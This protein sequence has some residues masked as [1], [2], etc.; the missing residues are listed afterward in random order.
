M[1]GNVAK[2]LVT[3]GAGYVGSHTLRALLAAGHRAVVLDDLRA[4]RAAFTDGAELVRGDVGAPSSLEHVFRAHGPFD[5]V[6]HFAGSIQVAESV[7]EPLA[8]YRN[9]VSASEVLLSACVREGV[10]CFAFSSSAAVYGHP[11]AQ[12]FSK[13]AAL[14]PLSEDAA[15][16]PL[17]PYGASKAMVER[18]LADAAAAHGLRYAAL[19][20][21]NAAGA[22]PAGGLGECHE[23]ETHLIPLA[24]RA[25]AG[26]GPALRLFGD[27]WPTRDG[28][29]ERDY[30]HVSDLGEA[31]CLALEALLA[32]EPGGAFNLGTGAGHTV[33]E[34]I[35]AVERA[36]GRPVP[37]EAAP[38]R[39]GDP[40]ALVADTTR[41]RTRFGWTPRHSDLDTIVR[42]A[43]SW[44][45]QRGDGV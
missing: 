27:D 14:A 23:P 45:R 36:V 12:P 7:R 40:A 1:G 34:V 44:E 25:A 28:S 35:A 11:E 19:R 39:P 8:Y 6:L 41:F 42:T 4:G 43:W 22:D 32:G 38:R 3:G 16:A 37:V 26:S 17:S 18:M 20:Y 30:V 24:L 31:H 13:N 33:R 5:G 10:S 15:L 29:C 2:V 21:F 9:N